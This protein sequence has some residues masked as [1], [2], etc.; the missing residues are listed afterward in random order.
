VTKEDKTV[1]VSETLCIG[2]GI[3]QKKCPFKALQILNLPRDMDKYTVHRYGPN[4]FKLHRLPI[5]RPGEVLGLIG[6]NG[7]GKSTVLNILSGKMKPNLGR[8]DLPPEWPEI[9]QY[10]RGSELQGYFT[11]RDKLKA[12]VKM[13]FVNNITKFV[14]GIVK[15][16][17]A[18]KDERHKADEVISLLHL[19]NLLDKNVAILSGGELQRLAIAILYIQE[20]DVYIF[21]E[22]SSYLDVKERVAAVRLIRRLLA[23]NK[24]VIVVEHDLAVLDYLSDYIC[25]LYGEPGAYGIVSAPF[26]VREGINVFIEGKVPTENVR[27]R[28]TCLTFRDANEL[29]DEYS[30]SWE[31][32]YPAMTCTLGS[33]VLHVGPGM[34]NDSQ[35]IV[36]LGENGTGKTTFIRML[37]GLLHADDKTVKVPV[38]NVSYKPQCIN[39]TTDN[40]VRQHLLLKMPQAFSDPQFITDV[41]KP[42]Q[43]EKLLDQQLKTLSGG[44][45][46]RVAIT[47]CLGKPADIYLIDEPSA[48]LDSEQRMIVAKLL[49]HFIVHSKR[50]AFVV[51]HDL[52]MATYLADRV[53]IYSGI[54]GKECTAHS[55]D[56]VARGLDSFLRTLEITFRH[57]PTNDRPRIN[58]MDSIKDKEQKAAGR[59]FFTE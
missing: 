32:T 33:F 12:I 23:P 49:K 55:P 8:F 13:Q 22:P 39:P 51:E 21:D 46:Q 3:C 40:T 9:I 25:V 1:W 17:I 45:I 50:T 38:L 24:Y 4:S 54:P 35:I 5:P 44:E 19:D 56:A 29:Q 11:Q 20:A 16:I 41:I 7:I 47:L 28:D 18:A 42:L 31:R 30:S 43:I 37:A 26:G 15:D 58:K 52:C 59:Y 2:C 36:L 48:Y 27:F 53:I 57:D 6:I 34:Y 14:H 10:F